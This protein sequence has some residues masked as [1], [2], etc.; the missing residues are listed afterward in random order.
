MASS[1]H[2]GSIQRHVEPEATS[3]ASPRRSKRAHDAILAAAAELLHERPYSD[4]CIE[5]IAARAG[6]GKQT[7]YRWWTS[8]AA[9][10]MEACAALV[11]REVPLPDTGSVQSDLRDYLTHICAFFETQ[12]SRPTI[13]GLLA[14]AQSNTELA[15]AF[16]QRLLV[17]RRAVLRTILER[18]VQRGELRADADLEVIIDMVHG[19]LWYRTL[20]LKAPLDA[21]LIEHLI[22]QILSGMVA[23]KPPA[24][25][26]AQR[27]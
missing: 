11:A 10:L 25:P 21:S 12:L 2:Y 24:A 3:G 7:I 5:A 1:G 13:A 17:Q 19:A 18:A 15:Q 8:K 9:V 6:V 22:H 23:L 14:E 26:Q 16:E 27:A 20:F 4:V